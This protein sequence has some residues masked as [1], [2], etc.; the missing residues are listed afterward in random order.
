VKGQGGPICH[1]VREVVDLMYVQFRMKGA[2]EEWE[3]RNGMPLAEVKVAREAIRNLQEH[4]LM[5]IERPFLD[6]LDF[7]RLDDGGPE[8]LSPG[9]VSPRKWIGS[10]ASCSRC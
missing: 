7:G 3:K 9:R 5:Y 4:P 8:L 2:R 10:F 6:E 1:I